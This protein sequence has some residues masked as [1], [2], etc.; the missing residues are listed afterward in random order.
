MK[1]TRPVAFV[2]GDGTEEAMNLAFGSKMENA[3]KEWIVANVAVPPVPDYSKDMSIHAFVH[4]DLVNDDFT[5]SHR[6]R[7]RST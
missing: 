6:L 2:N 3:R 5:H 4:T 7:D 1:A